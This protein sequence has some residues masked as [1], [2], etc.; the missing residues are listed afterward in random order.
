MV[1]ASAGQVAPLVAAQV[2]PVSA[3]PL[4][5][6]RLDT[7]LEAATAVV[8]R[9]VTSNCTEP[10]LPKGVVGAAALI[11]TLPEGGGGSLPP[12]PLLPPPP[13][14]AA[15]SDSIAVARKFLMFMVLPLCALCPD[16]LQEDGW[17]V[18]SGAGTLSGRSCR[19]GHTP[20]G[21]TAQS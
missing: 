7:T 19:I 18:A 14:H 6:V 17:L 15:T 12:P 20:P 5:R 3:R 11:D 8:L 4:P 16:R 10:P 9:I 21:R 1:A 2:T 13:P